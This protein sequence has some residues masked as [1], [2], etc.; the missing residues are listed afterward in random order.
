MWTD[1][2]NVQTPEP[3]VVIVVL[4]RNDFLRGHGVSE[5]GSRPAAVICGLEVKL[6][7]GQARTRLRSHAG[8][9]YECKQQV[10]R[11]CRICVCCGFYPPGL[12]DVLAINR[13]STDSL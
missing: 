8:R 5:A 13:R 3:S 1:A 2:I 4:S 7:R 10:R 9:G 11:T 6:E 12:P